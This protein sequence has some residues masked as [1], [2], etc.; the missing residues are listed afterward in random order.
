MSIR[1][2]N[3]TLTEKP[4]EIKSLDLHPWPPPRLTDWAKNV[5]D[6]A[7]WLIEGIVPA[8]GATLISGRQ[9]VSF[10]SFLAFKLA[11]IIAT[12][13]AEGPF[14][15]V[16]KDGLPVLFM[17][18]DGGAI[19]SKD[20][21][22]KVCG[23]LPEKLYWAHRYPVVLNDGAWVDRIRKL[24]IE[25][26]IK[27]I[28][29]DPWVM[30]STSDEKDAQQVIQ[31]LNA[32]TVFKNAGA[33][34]IFVHHIRKSSYGAD[35]QISATDIDDDV[36]GTTA[37]TGYYD[38]HLAVR[39]RSIS[40]IHNDVHMRFKD[41]Q[42]SSWRMEWDVG[43]TAASVQFTDM[44]SLGGL[45]L[46]GRELLQDMVPSKTYNVAKVMDILGQEYDVVKN[47]LENLCSEGKLI[48]IKGKGYKSFDST[49]GVTE[50][51][52]DN[53]IDFP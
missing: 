16:H 38:A 6:A 20:R 26:G 8:D 39:K 52:V 42:P 17:E 53:V 32:F 37:L 11:Q 41:A 36:R 12:G 23:A 15:P 48:F 30:F 22:L 46:L 9:K 4:N 25:Y 29:F 1:Y 2:L 33:S 10:K 7:P 18:N 14:V 45:R 31:V 13:K 50:P 49:T 40:Q 43:D 44:A 3:D 19:Q 34:V 27:A 28:V 47:V 21:W 35:G 51:E 24:I 5:P